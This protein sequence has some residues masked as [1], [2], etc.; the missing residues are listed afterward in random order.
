MLKHIFPRSDTSIWIAPA[1]LSDV[2][3]GGILASYTVIHLT[4][5][6]CDKQARGLPLVALE[7]HTTSLVVC[8]VLPCSYFTPAGCIGLGKQTDLK[9]EGIS[10]TNFSSGKRWFASIFS[11][12]FPTHFLFNLY[13]KARLSAKHPQDNMVYSA[14]YRAKQENRGAG[15]VDIAI[16][17]SRSRGQLERVKWSKLKTDHSVINGKTCCRVNKVP[18]SASSYD[19][20][21]FLHIT[22]TCL[23]NRTVCVW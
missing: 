19:R 4:I 15:D 8:P 20:L 14:L 17:V 11:I 23:K 13:S 1:C 6:S 7:N 10:N 18:L 2:E 5:Y 9:E 3:V 21:H 16:C 22:T 12:I